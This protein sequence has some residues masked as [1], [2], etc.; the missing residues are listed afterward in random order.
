MYSWLHSFKM[1]ASTLN[2]ISLFTSKYSSTLTQVIMWLSNFN[3]YWSNIWPGVSILWL[4]LCTCCVYFVHHLSDTNSYASENH[5]SLSLI[6]TYMLARPLF[7]SKQWRKLTL[8]MWKLHYRLWNWSSSKIGLFISLLRVRQLG[9]FW[10][11]EGSLSAALPSPSS[12][13][14]NPGER[15]NM[16]SSHSPGST[17]FLCFCLQSVEP[18]RLTSC[19]QHLIISAE[20]WPLPNQQRCSLGTC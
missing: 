6:H 20:G 9:N 12:S 15:Q 14:W 2:T 4:K 7:E 5:L 3:L 1:H 8:K 16:F 13:F 17:A 19:F 10:A 11:A 18:H